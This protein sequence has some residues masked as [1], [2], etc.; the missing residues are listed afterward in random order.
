MFAHHAS[1]YDGKPSAADNLSVSD[2]MVPMQK[3][4]YKVTIPKDEVRTLDVSTL[5]RSSIG[6]MLHTGMEQALENIEGYTQEV[7]SKTTIEGVTVSGKFDICTPD[8]EVRDLKN[9]SSF[10]YGLFRQDLDNMEA[11]M[12]IA[13]MR[14][15]YPNYWKYVFQL[16]CYRMLNQDIITQPYG[17]ILFNLTSSSFDNYDTYNEHRLPLFDLEELMDYLTDYIKQFKQHLADGTKPPCTESERIHK[18]G[19]FKLTRMGS[20]GKWSTV[21]GSKFDD[22]TQFRNFVTNKGK[23]GDREVVIEASYVACEWCA[24]SDIC[25]Q[26]NP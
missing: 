25:E 10:A 3:L 19:S 11:G 20:T 5:A 16:S 21:R 24:Y 23:V 4:L 22:L 2:F 8:G 9:I 15:S 12:S 18:P 13:D 6:T 26:N 7:R 1:L 17:T 14:N